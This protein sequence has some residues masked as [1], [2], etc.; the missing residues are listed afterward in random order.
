MGNV[1]MLRK[2]S[3]SSIATI[4]LVALLLTLSYPLVSDLYPEYEV[5]FMLFGQFVAGIVGG[6]FVILFI[7]VIIILIV[8]VVKRAVD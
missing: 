1:A 5:F 3:V 6:T 7:I 4:Y 8:S 2:I